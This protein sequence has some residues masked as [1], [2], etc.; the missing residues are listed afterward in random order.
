LFDMAP[1]SPE[2]AGLASLASQVTSLGGLLDG[3]S[4]GVQLLIFALVVFHAGAIC[5]WAVSFSR[6]LRAPSRKPEGYTR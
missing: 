4:A 2:A 6:E 1:A 5:V 3:Q